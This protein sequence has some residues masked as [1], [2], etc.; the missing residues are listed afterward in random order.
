MA[1]AALDTAREREGQASPAGARKTLALTA[2]CIVAGEA[3]LAHTAA[4]V[5]DE[6][7]N[8]LIGLQEASGKGGERAPKNEGIRGHRSRGHTHRWM[9]GLAVTRLGAARSLPGAEI[10][11]KGAA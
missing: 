5:D 11:R 8:L 3:S 6:R 2:G 9:A 1:G 10:A 7:L 4:V